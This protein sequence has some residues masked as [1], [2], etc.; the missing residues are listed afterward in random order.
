M[1]ENMKYFLVFPLVIAAL[2]FQSLVFVAVV[3]IAFVCILPMMI[4]DKLKKMWRN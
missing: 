1:S 3:P 4:G 2:L